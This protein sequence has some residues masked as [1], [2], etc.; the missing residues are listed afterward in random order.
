MVHNKLA[1]VLYNSLQCTIWAKTFEGL[2]FC[3]FLIL[4]N[5]QKYCPLVFTYVSTQLYSIKG[6]T[7]IFVVCLDFYCVIQYMYFN[8]MTIFMLQLRNRSVEM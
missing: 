8:T 1:I 7:S 6:K 4:S 5:A 2:N 3:D